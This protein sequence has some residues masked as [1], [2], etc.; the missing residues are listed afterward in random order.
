M[1]RTPAPV[2]ELLHQRLNSYAVAASAA[3]VSL[4]ALAQPA[5][6][7]IIYTKTNI[8]ISPYQQH[9]YDLSLN[10]NKKTEFEIEST[11]TET[12]NASAGTQ[13]V[14]IAAIK[15]NG[16][17]ASNGGAAALK[18]GQQISSKDDFDGRWM[19]SDLWSAGAST[20]IKRGNWADVSNRYLGLRFKIS[21]KTHYGWARLTVQA[22]KGYFYFFSTLTGYAYETIPN[23]PII[24]GKT[25]GPDIITV[26]P[27]SLGALAL[28]ASGPAAWRQSDLTRAPR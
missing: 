13:H 17:A 15:G 5:E 22:Q 12:T 20:S 23:K 25:S 18:K 10:N 6:A 27:A 21:G 7:K 28:G 2:S 3:G 24:A 16:V 26:Q 14:F 8:V 19:A 11:W 4:L 9:S 1:S